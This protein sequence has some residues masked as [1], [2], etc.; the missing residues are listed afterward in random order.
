MIQ[1]HPDHLIFT[2]SNGD[3]IPC[4]A[5]SITIELIGENG[6]MLDPEMLRQAATAV[7]HYFRVEL[8]KE[9]VTVEEFS[10]A[11]E[12]VLN[13]F[14]FE[15]VATPAEEPP[16]D[17]STLVDE[18]NGVSEL[19]FYSRLRELLIHRVAESKELVRFRGLRPCAKRLAGAKR[20]CPRCD[21]VSDQ[22]LDYMRGLFERQPA[23]SGRGLVVV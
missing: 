6:Q 10:K 5:E 1:L 16:P 2:T 11:L 8:G 15:V 4:S 20:W 21:Q 13:S 23:A 12:K 14:G 7:V 3:K 19:M 22:I 9:T 18:R 17:L